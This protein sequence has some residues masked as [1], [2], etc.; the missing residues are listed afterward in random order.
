MAAILLCTCATLAAQ[1][2]CPTPTGRVVLTLR[3]AQGDPLVCDLQGLERLPQQHIDTR[4][5]A[6]LGLAGQHRWRGVPLAELARALGAGPDSEIR[7]LAL[8][9]YAVSVPMSDVLRF[10]PVLASRRNG[11][12]LAVRDKGPLILIYPF[13][14]H[15]ELDDPEYLN[16]SI[17]QVHEIRLR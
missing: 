14:R 13:G 7:L 4:L 17:W 10:N 8:N 15:R 3:A 2:L 1:P 16:R 5:P 6:A 9:H 12:P 11:E